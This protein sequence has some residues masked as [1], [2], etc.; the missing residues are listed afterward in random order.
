MLLQVGNLA[1]FPQI[2]IPYGFTT[3]TAP[4]SMSAFNIAFSPRRLPLMVGIYGGPY[5]DAEVGDWRTANMRT[6][7]MHALSRHS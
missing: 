4:S 5:K 6:V 3:P 1:N 7:H 2:S